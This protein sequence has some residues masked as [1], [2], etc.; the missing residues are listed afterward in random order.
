[1]RR[2]FFAAVIAGSL[3]AMIGCA[4]GSETPTLPV[5]SGTSAAQTYTAV[6]WDERGNTPATL[7]FSYTEDT[8]AKEIL[9]ALGNMLDVNWDLISAEVSDNEVRLVCGEGSV[10]ATCP[11]ET[12]L[13][14]LLESIRKT[15]HGNYGQD[16]E[17]YLT[18]GAGMTRFGIDLTGGLPLGREAPNVPE[19]QEGDLT[20]AD[21]ETYAINLTYG[22]LG[23][24]SVALTTR[25]NQII[26]IEDTS[27]YDISVS[28]M[29]DPD[30]IMRR[31]AISFDGVTALVYNVFTDS[32][33]YF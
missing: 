31:F 8:T 30:S 27:Y 32:F 29:S 19:I 21:A 1:M 17:V 33:E 2:L 24:T 14:G 22:M 12:E 25:L 15:I 6:L 28:S 3:L 18:V 5:T 10:L 7:P 11:E 9:D 4:A 13:R 16:K 20:L 26:T 23:D